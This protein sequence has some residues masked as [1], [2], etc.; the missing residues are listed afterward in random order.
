M[1]GDVDKLE[2][3]RDF[4]KSA[5][6]GATIPPVSLDD[7]KRLHELSVDMRKHYSGKDGILSVDVM[8]RA[9]DPGANVPAVWLRHVELKSLVRQ[10]VLSDWQHEAGLDNAVYHV[11]AKI[12]MQ[13]LHFDQ[14]AFLKQLR[15]ESAIK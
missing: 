11:A 2:F 13:G 10:G 4:I 12:P 1:A 3:F 7:L 9:C 15:I 14:E 6:N 8:A 5:E